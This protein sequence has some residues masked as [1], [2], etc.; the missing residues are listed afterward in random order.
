MDA[1]RLVF[2]HVYLPMWQ[3]DWKLSIDFE[4]GHFCCCCWCFSFSIRL[5]LS[6]IP[7]VLFTCNIRVLFMR[8]NWIND[9]Q[10]FWWRSRLAF[11]RN[12]KKKGKKTNPKSWA[13]AQKKERPLSQ[14]IRLVCF[15]CF[16]CVVVRTCSFIVSNK[17]GKNMLIRLF[18]IHIEVSSRTQFNR[19][20]LS[21]QN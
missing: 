16:A 14:A 15:I 1:V 2:C 8:R 9:G 21:I 13:R 6:F 5:L 20:K 4:I 10:R 18:I 17:N 7:C 3:S 12:N 11:G 19:M